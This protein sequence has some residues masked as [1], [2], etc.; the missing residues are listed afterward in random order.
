[1]TIQKIGMKIIYNSDAREYGNIR[2]KWKFTEARYLPNDMVNP[3][4]IDIFP[5]SVL[6]AIILKNPIAF[7]VRDREFAD[8]FRNYFEIMWKNSRK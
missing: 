4:W 8:S 6:F 3:N 2:N 5:D 1:M 7:V